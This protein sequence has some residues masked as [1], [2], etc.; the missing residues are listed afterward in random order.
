[1]QRLREADEAS[2]AAKAAAD[3]AQRK[4]DD[5]QAEVAVLRRRADAAAEDRQRMEALEKELAVDAQVSAGQA[6]L[7]ML[8]SRRDFVT[9]VCRLARVGAQELPDS[10]LDGLS[11]DTAARLRAFFRGAKQRV[12]ELTAQLVKLVDVQV[13][14]LLCARL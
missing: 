5:L 10:V 4:W 13:C 14:L 3:E 7:V 9:R 6:Q 11:P 2:A 8:G 12:A 1:M